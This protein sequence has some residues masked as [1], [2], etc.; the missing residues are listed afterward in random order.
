[1]WLFFKINKLTYSFPSSYILIWY[2]E[3]FSIFAKTVF[4]QGQIFKGT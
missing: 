2:I 1:M 3:I 4:P